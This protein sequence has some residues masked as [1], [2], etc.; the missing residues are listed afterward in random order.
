MIKFLDRKISLLVKSIGS[1]NFLSGFRPYLFFLLIGAALY[2][3]VVFFDFTYLDDNALIIDNHSY[4]SDVSNIGKIFSSDVFLSTNRNFYRPILNLSFMIDTVVLGS[5]PGV[6]H[7]VNVLLHILA[8][9]L[10][11]ILFLKF[12][13]KRQLAFFLAVLFLVHP[14]A[15]QA[16]AWI[17]G[18][19]DLLL[20]VFGL[21]SW[22]LFLSFSERP[23]LLFYLGHLVCFWLAILTKETAVFLP[24]LTI[25]YF[26]FIR[27]DRLSRQD[28]WLLVVGSGIVIFFWLLMRSFA[29]G[30]SGGEIG[31]ALLTTI[32]SLPALLIYLGKLL[33]PFNL[34]VLPIL[35][36]SSLLYGALSLVVITPA[37]WFSR[38]K[39]WEYIIFGLLWYGLFLL[40]SFVRLIGLPDFLEHRSYLPLVGFLLV[41][42]EIDWVSGRVK[43]EKIRL[44]LA[45]ALL[46]LF[47]LISFFHAGVFRGRLEFWEAAVSGSP[48]SPLALRNL[49]VMYYLEG[50]SDE[51]LE[52]YLV[53]VSLSPNEPMVNNNI[54]VIYLDQKKYSEAETAFRRELEVNPGY[55][56]ALFN[57]GESYYF[58]NQREAATRYWRAALAANPL[59]QE[60]RGRLLKWENPI[61]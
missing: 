44:T 27:P 13:R 57:L 15:T 3:R 35:A 36:D 41:F 31:G 6:Y 33:F 9:S 48:H 32:S 55:D 43:W 2:G 17:P 5:S 54:G 8:A 60:A 50:R 39:R 56:K 34:K 25:F 29:L 40:P 45:V 16:V 47:G 7:L 61:Q 18:R 58:R 53:A 49:G 1:F 14:L 42:A 52:H 26:L 59:N 37:L 30:S 38:F 23:R 12:G 10:V 20:G 28:R 24:L 4:I 46:I 19:N 11:F 22:L 51:A 21:A